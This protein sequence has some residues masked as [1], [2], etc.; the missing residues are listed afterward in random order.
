M[1]GDDK[2]KFRDSLTLPKTT[3]P[4]VCN[5]KT[6]ESDILLKWQKNEIFKKKIS[7]SSETNKDKNIFTLP[8]G[9]PYANGPIHLGHALNAVLKDIVIKSKYKSGSTI[10]FKFVSDCHGL[11]IENK[12]VEKLKINKSEIGNDPVGFKKS[13]RD[14][15][16]QWISLQKN[17]FA[18]LGVLADFEN[19]ASTMD[20]S[21][22]ADILRSFGKIWEN[23][24][25]KQQEK[26]LNWCANCATV[27]SD[28]E[29]EYKD[30]EDPSVFVK[31]KL[32]KNSAEN[33][34]KKFNIDQNAEINF[35]VWT[36]TPWTLPL[37]KAL[38]VHPKAEYVIVQ[39]GD[40]NYIVGANL[41][42]K[43]AQKLNLQ[44]KVLANFIA[45]EEFLNFSADHIL[46]SNET[47]PVIFDENIGLDEGTAIVHIAPGC[48]PQ[49]YLLGVRNKLEI[50]SPVDGTGRYTSGVKIEELIG[51]SVT[52]NGQIK[53]IEK[54]KET[55]KLVLLEKINHSYPCCWR[56]RKGIIWRA[57]KQWFIDL[58]K[59]QL[60]EKT[61]SECEKIEFIPEWGKARFQS[62]IGNRQEWCISR[63]RSW[64]VPI[65]ALKCVDCEEIFISKQL[66]A[67]VANEITKMGI[68]FWDQTNI[69]ELKNIGAIEPT[70]T[71]KK[72]NQKNFVKEKDTLD[73]WFDSGVF[74]TAILKNENE[75]LFPM[76]I[77]LEGSDQHRGW[78]QSSMLTSM[79]MYGKACTQRILT[80]GFLVD[81]NGNKMSKSLG[82]GVE[83]NQ[84][85]EKFGRDVLRLWVASSDYS[86]DISVSMGIITSLAENYRKIRNTCRFML[87][88]ISDLDI[89]SLVEKDFINT[90]DWKN[91]SLVDRYA[92]EKLKTLIFQIDEN[93]K[94]FNFS[95][96]MQDLNHF[97]VISMSSEYFEMTKDRLYAD[98]K[99]GQPRRATQTTML[100][101]LSFLIDR[102][103]PI[104]SFLAE[105][106]TEH[107]FGK[108]KSCFDQPNL[109]ADFLTEIC[110]RWDNFYGL[111]NAEKIFDLLKV[112][113]EEIFKKVEQKR[114]IGEINQFLEAKVDFYVNA[115]S[116]E[117]E[118]FRNLKDVLLKKDGEFLFFKTWFNVSEAVN[119]PISQTLENTR[120]P[121]LFCQINKM[122]GTKCP[123][124]WLWYKDNNPQN[125][126]N[127]CFVVFK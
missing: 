76:S 62:F 55:N 34:L 44:G 112:A 122:T 5:F 45:E 12:V 27:L 64:G 66:I 48:G 104:L 93:F 9:P 22:E 117:G 72:C 1:D 47:V 105:D 67:V 111:N 8:W 106:L 97:C 75:K 68:E 91:I 18:N 107:L 60:Q 63:Q 81:A 10:H 14:F 19:S 7:F 41:Y 77:M 100:L 120:E 79:L 29:I 109:S 52:G 95:T 127:R 94:N 80:H 123:R 84:I 4:I 42:E 53:V 23:G 57:T 103:S 38:S 37:N 89:Q 121:W 11:P 36:T 16:Q 40:K 17:E 69:E 54:L 2:K 6:T 125:L 26:A 15:V 115:N 74:H 126:C 25:V 102:I 58:A 70:L 28:A 61:L 85:I 39:M 21:Y 46:Q 20:F 98:E 3:F 110:S 92:I 82:N 101:I 83:P 118:L 88:N 108:D 99:N 51:L 114:E 30:R 59:N 116:L 73:V 24:F 78:F 113:R 90:F 13:C 35:L 119:H 65:V 124:C 86:G 32:T 49:D 87:A 96:I 31:F 50:F 43:I 71:C 33:L 56:C